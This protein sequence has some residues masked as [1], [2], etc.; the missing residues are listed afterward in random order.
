MSS[1]VAAAGGLRRISARPSSVP[2]PRRADPRRRPLDPQLRPR[3]VGRLGRNR[4]RNQ[5]TSPEAIRAHA[6]RAGLPVDETVSLADMVLVQPDPVRGG[7]LRE[8]EPSNESQAHG[9][10]LP[11]WPPWSPRSA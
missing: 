7:G 1:C 11:R 3:R 4:L 5:A 8:G 2:A 9:S 6:E 10:D